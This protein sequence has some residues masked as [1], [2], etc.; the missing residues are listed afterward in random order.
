MKRRLRTGYEKRYIISYIERV[1]FLI[2]DG[3]FCGVLLLGLI[4][5]ERSLSIYLLRLSRNSI[6]S[7]GQVS[8]CEQR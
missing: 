6:G 1:P 3:V 2:G 5:R 8:V 4:G 7:G